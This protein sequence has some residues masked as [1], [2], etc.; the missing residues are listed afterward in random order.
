MEDSKI[1]YKKYAED[2]AQI[3]TVDLSKKAEILDIHVQDQLFVFDFF[4]QQIVFDGHDFI[5]I[6]G[7]EVTDAVKVVL[8]NYI[9]KCPENEFKASNQL[10]TFREFSNA[11]PLFSRFTE[12]TGKVITTTFS[13]QMDTLKSRCQNLGATIAD[14]QS[15]DLSANF[16]ALPRVPIILNF[17]DTDE[18]MPAKAGFLFH[19][20]AESYLDLECLT[21]ISTYL[22]GLLISIAGKPHH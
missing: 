14:T 22:T 12:N 8:C 15:Y 13:G 4:N 6:Q 10:V 7:H 20:D 1:F 9:L 3:K 17:N 18:L 11:G 2:L 5:D 19:D 21:I 16:R